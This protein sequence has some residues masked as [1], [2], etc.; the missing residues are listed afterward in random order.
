M[1]V[2]SGL[3]EDGAVTA[4]ASLMT[5]KADC[6]GRCVFMKRIIKQVFPQTVPVL[7][8]Y[9]SL[10]MA[11]GLMLQSIGYGPVWAFI[12]SLFIY[13]GSAE[14]LAVEL[15]SA[16]AALTK[17]ALLTFLL[18]FR[19]MFYGLSMIEKYHGT[20][21]RKPYLIFGLTD[22]TYAILT[23]YKV[24]EGISE[25]TYYFTVTLLNHIYWILGSVIG[26][27]AGSVIPFDTTGIDFAMTA[28]F[29][30]LVVEQW[31]THKNHVPAILGLAIAVASLCIFGADNFLIPALTAISAV[32][33]LMRG[34][35]SR[36]EAQ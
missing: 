22:E 33:L 10:G 7:A 31:K 29:A 12:M 14:F 21:I 34:S 13:A 26:A 20:G 16:G 5:D 15:L 25:K 6:Y 36:E 19:H 30:V 28:L 1:C 18:N 35:L 24:P 4:N 23:G 17:V 32:L 9:I 3:T 2:K 27:V 8:G 11:F